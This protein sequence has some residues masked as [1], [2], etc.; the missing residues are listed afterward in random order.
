M[1]AQGISSPGTYEATHS[2]GLAAMESKMECYVG[3]DVSLKQTSICVVRDGI[4]R[5]RRRS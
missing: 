4:G 2:S 1:K 5:A 3:L